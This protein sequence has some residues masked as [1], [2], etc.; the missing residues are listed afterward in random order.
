MQIVA[1]ISTKG[2]VGKTTLVANVAVALGL[3]GKRVLAVDM[4]PQNAL[5]RHLGLYPSE[6]WGIAHDGITED[7]IYQSPFGIEFLPFGNLLPQDCLRLE[8]TFHANPEWLRRA[9]EQPAFKRFDYVLIDSPSLSGSFMKQVLLAADHSIAVMQS[10]PA[11]LITIADTMA[12]ATS[13]NGDTTAHLL[14]NQL[15]VEKR[16][17]YEVYSNILSEYA[18][19]LAPFPV[20][21][22]ASVSEAL[23]YERPV[24]FYEPNSIA[25]VDIISLA[26]WLVTYL[27]T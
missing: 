6:P 21:Y 22:D 11:S 13:L 8:R 2:G 24:L 19:V 9:L 25:T 3:Q 18:S 23:A 16:L 14:V 5:G 7:S 1:F 20:H 17:A 10:E 12:L 26:K 27:D 15:P 4:D